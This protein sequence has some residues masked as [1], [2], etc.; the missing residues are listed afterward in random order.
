ME[1]HDINPD[2]LL[3][4]KGYDSDD[5]RNDLADR[6][7]ELVIPPRSNRKTPIKY[8]R[9]AYRRRD[10]IERCVNRLKQFRRIAT[11]YEKSARAYLSMLCIGAARLW[12]KT[13]NTP[14][15]RL[16]ESGIARLRRFLHE[17]DGRL[18]CGTPAVIGKAYFTSLVL[19][20]DGRHTHSP[21]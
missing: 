21:S 12:I 2:R 9:E 19:L 20:L 1:L 15:V 17:V 6:G 7:I 14:L 3:G 5:I 18:S 8:D 16:R 13:V 4:D 10:L 11:R